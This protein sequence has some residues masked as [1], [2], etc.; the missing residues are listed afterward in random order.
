VPIDGELRG[1]KR[2]VSLVPFALGLGTATP[3]DYFFAGR[4]DHL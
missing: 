1:Q 2:A 4:P 3:H